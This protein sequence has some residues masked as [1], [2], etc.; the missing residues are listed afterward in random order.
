LQENIQVPASAPPVLF[1]FRYDLLILKS[2]NPQHIDHQ[3]VQLSG[4]PEDHFRT[5]TP[6]C[7]VLIEYIVILFGD[8][9]I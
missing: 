3:A 5:V 1:G 2:G 9:S 7:L 8:I 4:G 6:F